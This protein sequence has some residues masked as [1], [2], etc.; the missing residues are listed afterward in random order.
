MTQ[1]E[2]LAMFVVGEEWEATIT[3]NVLTPPLIITFVIV[4]PPKEE[5]VIERPS[6]EVGHPQFPSEINIIEARPGYLHYTGANGNDIV[7]EKIP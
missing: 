3:Y 2:I 1:D 6:G 5:F 4:G 7:L